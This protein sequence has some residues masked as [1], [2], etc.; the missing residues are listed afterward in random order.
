MA[1]NKSI[2][3]FRPLLVEV[4]WDDPRSLH[5]NFT[6]ADVLQGKGV[7]L[8]LDRKTYGLFCYYNEEYLELYSDFDEKD[9][10]VGGGTAILWVLVKRVKIV[11][12]KV[13]YVR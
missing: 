7:G 9:Q 2:K 1:P 5:D 12:G 3:H 4:T 10:E 8:Q 6:L 11:N 13:I